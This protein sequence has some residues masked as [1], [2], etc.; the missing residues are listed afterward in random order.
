MIR[1]EEFGI[2]SY[3]I[4]CSLSELTRNEIIVFGYLLLCRNAKTGQCNPK[5]RT[6]ATD[7]NLAPPRVTEA[8]K[9]LEKKQWIVWNGDG[10]FLLI[11]AEEKVTENVTFKPENN[12]QKV[13]ENVI[14]QDKKVTENVTRSYGKRN[15]EVTENVTQVTENVTRSLKDLE[16]RKN[17]EE[18]QRREVVTRT[19]HAREAFSQFVSA[20]EIASQTFANEQLFDDRFEPFIAGLKL[21]LKAK[22]QLPREAEWLKTFELWVVNE[23]SPENFLAIYDTL[24]RIAK[25]KSFNVSPSVLAN[26]YGRLEALQQE[27]ELSEKGENHGKLSA[28]ELR[29]KNFKEQE[30]LLDKYKRQAE[31]SRRATGG[32][33]DSIPSGDIPNRAVQFKIVLPKLSN[34]GKPV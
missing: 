12:S 16:Q 6:I 13:T 18:E 31:E 33:G 25:K 4:I 30:Q 32:T 3:E 21:R 22:N 29:E 19:T 11:K 34:L 9:G 2:F 1:K 28:A 23:E 7:T 14:S 27:L 10:N 26:N 24:C 20:Q 17:K 5:L 15:S 8:V